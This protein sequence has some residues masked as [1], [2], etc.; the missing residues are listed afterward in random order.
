MS[1]KVKSQRTGRKIVRRT[2]RWARQAHSLLHSQIRGGHL[3]RPDRCEECGATGV[4]IEGAH[5]NYNEP[6]NVRW[7]CRSCHVKWDRINPKHATY[8]VCP[9]FPDRCHPDKD[10]MENEAV[11]ISDKTPTNAEVCQKVGV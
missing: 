10:F 4:K 6:L 9:E 7:L 8:R 5:S 2:H 3:V 11:R 1:C